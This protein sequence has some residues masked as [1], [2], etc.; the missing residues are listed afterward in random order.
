MAMGHEHAGDQRCIKRFGV[1]DWLNKGLTSVSSPTDPSDIALSTPS[2]SPSI[3]ILSSARRTIAAWAR[4][5][6]RHVAQTWSLEP[7]TGHASKQGEQE[8][9]DRD[10]VRALGDQSQGTR[11]HIPGVGTN[12]RS[13]N[14]VGSASPLGTFPRMFG[15]GATDGPSCRRVSRTAANIPSECYSGVLSAPL[16]LLAQEDS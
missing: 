7:I 11:E 14:L 16:P 10:E 13:R 2:P 3:V 8:Q 12:H 9:F 4:T 5:G 6:P 15:E 1:A